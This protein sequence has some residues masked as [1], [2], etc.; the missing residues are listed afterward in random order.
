MVTA[1]PIFKAA[2]NQIV[3]RTPHIR[4]NINALDNAPKTAPKVLSEYKVPTSRPTNIR[5]CETYLLKTGSV[6]PI[7]E[8][9]ISR[10]TPQMKN[11]Y[12]LALE[13]DSV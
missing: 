7:K 2:A 4:I 13:Y 11:R 9:G 3:V 5:L 6:A 10:I 8:V 12:K 1:I